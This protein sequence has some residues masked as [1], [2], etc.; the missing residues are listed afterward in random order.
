VPTPLPFHHRKPSGNVVQHAA[1]IY[2]D[3]PVPFI[4]FQFFQLGKWHHSRI[5]YH[6][7]MSSTPELDLRDLGTQT[8]ISL[9]PSI[10]REQEREVGLRKVTPGNTLGTNLT[11][12]VV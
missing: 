6:G 3:H 12:K 4:C 5:V 11:M 8:G 1:D 7:V 2:I 10:Q 9:N